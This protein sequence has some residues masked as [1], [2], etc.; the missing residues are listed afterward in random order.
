NQ[1]PLPPIP[2]LPENPEPPSPPGVP[3][4]RVRVGAAIAAGVLA[5]LAAAVVAFGRPR[6]G[7]PV[8][9]HPAT[10]T[11][12]AVSTTGPAVSTT[13][14]AVSTTGPV[15]STS[16]PV[17]VTSGPRRPQAPDVTPTRHDFLRLNISHGHPVVTQTF[18]IT[19][20][21]ARPVTFAS[22]TTSDPTFVVA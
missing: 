11:G 16:R 7:P 17:V 18:T 6:P 5:A 1:L 14:P 8:A 10:P 22:A 13:R 12:P 21:N 3:G 15:V 9:N 4:R 19:N 2:P 20:P